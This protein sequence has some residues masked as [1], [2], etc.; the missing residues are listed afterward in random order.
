MNDAKVT[1]TFKREECVDESPDLSYLEQDYGDSPVA[2]REM[3]RAQDTERLKA[4]HNGDWHVLGIRA[5]AMIVVSR[6]G[7]STHYELTSPGLWGV[8]S[9]SGE[10]CLQEAFQNE[11]DTLRADIEAMRTAEFKL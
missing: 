5:V 11:C 9:D 2:E 3:Y 10:D 6:P 1:V 7:Y 4:Y 8:E